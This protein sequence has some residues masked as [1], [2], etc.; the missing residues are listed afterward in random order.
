MSEKYNQ[1]VEEPDTTGTVTDTTNTVTDTTGTVIGGIKIKLPKKK[2]RQIQSLFPE[3]PE[4]SKVIKHIIISP[5]KPEI[6]TSN[7]SLES[8]NSPNPDFMDPKEA[9]KYRNI[10][11]RKYNAIANAI[12]VATKA[13]SEAASEAA[14]IANDILNSE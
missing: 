1:W 4:Q 9:A 8:P 11:K 12:A 14:S 2:E 13:A 3:S 7:S 6:T 5:T 10:R